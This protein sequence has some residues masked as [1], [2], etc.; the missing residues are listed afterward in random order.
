MAA[1]LSPE[2]IARIADLAK[3]LGYFGPN[4]QE[5]ILKIALDDL[6]AKTPPPRLKMTA[7]QIASERKV[8]G[9]LRETGRKWRE[10]NPDQYDEKNP[11]SIAW[12]EELYDED[13]LP[14]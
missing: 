6:D 14:K 4:A 13:G 11:P 2:M 3:R 8:V 1:E 12:Q 7:E 9:R 10:A 5:Q